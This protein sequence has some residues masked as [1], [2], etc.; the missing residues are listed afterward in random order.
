MRRPLVLAVV[1]VVALVL[2]LVSQAKLKQAVEDAKTQEAANGSKQPDDAAAP[3]P[4]DNPPSDSEAP[5][6]V[7]TQQAAAP[8]ASKEE[9]AAVSKPIRPEP[10]EPLRTDPN[11]SPREQVMA[12]L[13]ETRQ[14]FQNRDQVTDDTKKDPHRTSSAITTAA[15]RLA[16]LAELALQNPDYQNDFNAFYLECIKDE[17]VIT[18]TRVQCLD[19]YVQAT[20]P[21]ADEKKALLAE[22]PPVVTRLFSEIDRGQ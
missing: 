21:S 15:G 18:I 19:R 9:A 4:R 13:L 6:S 16:D 8:D 10:A 7:P 14:I 20:K 5:P 11:Q 12:A 17:K 22:L 2:V 1:L 3:P